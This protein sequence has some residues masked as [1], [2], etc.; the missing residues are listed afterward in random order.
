MDTLSSTATT[1]HAPGYHE[2]N[3]I[4][5]RAEPRTL[6]VD[7]DSLST[8]STTSSNNDYAEEAVSVRD[9]N[10]IALV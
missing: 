3:V 4:L 5:P 7:N 8:F 2:G 6:S 1:P 9:R 10:F